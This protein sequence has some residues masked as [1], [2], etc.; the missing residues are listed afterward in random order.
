MRGIDQSGQRTARWQDA[1]GAAQSCSFPY[2]LA[3]RPKDR[4]AKVYEEISAT[5]MQPGLAAVSE[6]GK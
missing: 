1:D 2:Q 4:Q 5:C 6:A 3:S